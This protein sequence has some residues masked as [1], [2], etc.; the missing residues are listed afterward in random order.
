MKGIIALSLVA[1]VSPSFAIVKTDDIEKSIKASSMP[2]FKTALGRLD[3]QAIPPDERKALYRDL[4]YLATTVREQREQNCF[5]RKPEDWAG[6]ITT[7]GFLEDKRCLANGVTSAIY[8][9]LFLFLV[10]LGRNNPSASRKEAF[11]IGAFLSCGACYYLYKGL[12]CSAQRDE[13]AQ[14]QAIES[15]LRGKIATC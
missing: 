9:P 5:L 1:L 8:G 3:N 12:T 2:F 15:F 10:Y 14:A 13:I 7:T 11:A 4:L 6:S